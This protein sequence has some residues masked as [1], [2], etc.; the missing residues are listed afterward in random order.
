MST[1]PMDPV[2]AGFYGTDP[3]M[4]KHAQ[5]GS[6]PRNLHELATALTHVEGQPLE[7]TASEQRAVFDELVSF[8]QSGRAVAHS[9]FNEM[10]KAASEG[11]PGELVEFLGLQEPAPTDRAALEAELRRRITR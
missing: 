1:D 7:K 4:Q 5:A 10:E 6:M 8:D 2:L 11:S 3:E 9:I